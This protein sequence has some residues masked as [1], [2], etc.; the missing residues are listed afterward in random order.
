MH[1]NTT[2]SSIR[3]DRI[4]DSVDLIHLPVITRTIA[5]SQR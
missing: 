4:T 2:L 5:G 3:L 1:V